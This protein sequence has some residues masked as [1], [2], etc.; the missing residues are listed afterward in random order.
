MSQ[1]HKQEIEKIIEATRC[2]L[3]FKCYKSNFADLCKARDIG[4]EL[5]VEC[6]E[7]HELQKCNFSLLFGPVYFCQCPVRVYITKELHK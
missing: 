4:L 6:L 2:S 5:V 3:G 7:D 1:D